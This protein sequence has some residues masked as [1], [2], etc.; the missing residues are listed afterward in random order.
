M[1][2]GSPHHEMTLLSKL[3]SSSD[4]DKSKKSKSP[5]SSSPDV[6]EAQA[7]ADTG[8]FNAGRRDTIQSL[9][10]AD[11]SLQP[12]ASLSPRPSQD[13]S[14]LAARGGPDDRWRRSGSLGSST[15]S[16]DA[17]SS[18]SSASGSASQL[19]VPAPTNNFVPFSK[20]SSSGS[21]ALSSRVV[22]RREPE[23]RR[24]NQTCTGPMDFT[25]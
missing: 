21:S 10:G 23:V 1:Q 22:R 18:T 2:K 24:L 12:S 8:D 17:S 20:L 3:V 13:S 19:A 6:K 16:L 5:F 7:R 4:R 14:P 15:G 9:E 11:D 25:S